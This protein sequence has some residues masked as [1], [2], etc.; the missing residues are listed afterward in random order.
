M[1]DI[2]HDKPVQLTERVSRI[3]ASNGGVMTGPGTNTY[4]VGQKELA[5]IDPGPA[6]QSHID[7]ILAAVGDRLKWILVTHTHPDHSPAA[8][9]L[10]TATG[11]RVMGNKLSDN[12]GF[13]DDS[14][15]PEQSFAH[16]ECLSTDEFTVRALLTPG[17]VDNHI[18]YLVEEDGVLL[19]GDHIMQGSTVVIIP[20][21]GDMKD[22]IDSLRLLLDYP[23]SAIGPGH[24]FLIDNPVAEIQWLVDH[25][26]GREDKVVAGLS[27]CGLTTLDELTPVVY[28]D[29]DT[30]LHPIARYSL[31]A[32]IIKLQKEGRVIAREEQWELVAD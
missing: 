9:A 25:R 6:D 24:G 11:A 4:L 19:T 26:L 16:D 31:W 30:S 12:D 1:I 14:F 3:T 27:Q 17:H 23:L 13:Q 2:S 28:A 15:T 18:C 21:H 7:N 5:V 22:Y 8:Q 29:V 20:P 10:A 32:H